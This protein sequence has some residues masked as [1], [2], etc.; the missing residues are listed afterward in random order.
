MLNSSQSITESFLSELQ[1]CTSL[2]LNT[3]K[4]INHNINSLET[5]S[6]NNKKKYR[7]NLHWF[8]STYKGWK[9]PQS[10]TQKLLPRHKM[11]QWLCVVKPVYALIR[12]RRPFMV[13]STINITR[14][15]IWYI[16][17]VHFYMG[18]YSA[19]NLVDT[20]KTCGKVPLT[21]SS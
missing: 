11:C 14:A 15:F 4:Q 2:K 17:T 9:V 16:L 12:S 1:N 5:S 6:T 13:Y 20:T 10:Y 21:R 19:W 3:F 8:I 7:G 18:Y